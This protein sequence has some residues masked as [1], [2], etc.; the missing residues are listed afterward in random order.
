MSDAYDPDNVLDRRSAAATLQAHYDHAEAR[1][2]ALLA[3]RLGI[4]RGTAVSVGCGWHPGR[5][6][7]P[8]PAWRLVAN[9]LRPERAAHAVQSGTAEAVVRGSATA[10]ELPDGSVDVVL[11]RLVLHHIAYEGSVA[12]ALEEAA[13]V[14]RPGGALVAVEPNAWHPVGAALAGANRLGLGPA[15]H[16]TADD[17]PLS[18]RT[19]A[20]DARA[21]GLVPE[22]LGVTY[23]WRRLPRRVQRALQA[24][25]APLGTRPRSAALAHTI[26]LIGRKPIPSAAE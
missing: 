11:E 12:A 10:L 6:L 21:A 13:R 14:L 16:G 15:V 23:S 24:L 20:A 7:F 9:D 2:A 1:E 17:V 4:A 26:L 18:P 25:D 3:A 8:A 22:I 5:H 19:L